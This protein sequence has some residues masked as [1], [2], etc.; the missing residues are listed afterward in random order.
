M[1]EVYDLKRK[2]TALSVVCFPFISLKKPFSSPL[3]PSG[4]P[5]RRSELFFTLFR[6]C[7]QEKICRAC[8]CAADFFFIKLHD[9]YDAKDM[10]N[11]VRKHSAAEG[12]DDRNPSV[13][14]VGVG[15]VWN[16]H[17]KMRNPR[18][19][20]AGRVHCVTGRAAK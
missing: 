16:R 20:I 17:E 9:L 3:A 14:P 6:L 2:E 8:K 10:C 11:E 1:H 12:S 13:A 19:E 4:A 7:F 15:L 5:Y 18:A